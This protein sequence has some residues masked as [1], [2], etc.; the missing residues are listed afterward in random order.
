MVDNISGI[1][2]LPLGPSYLITITSPLTSISGNLDVGSGID[3]TG[4]ITCSVDLNI[5]GDI[6]MATGKK[7]TWVD[8]NQYIS[9]TATGITIETDDTFVVNSDTSTT[10]NTPSFLLSNSAPNFQIKSTTIR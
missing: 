9:G 3:V 7:L 10:F 6:D 1:P 2:G 5:E 8:D 4:T